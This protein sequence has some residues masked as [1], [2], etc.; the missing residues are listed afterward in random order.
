ME[1]ILKRKSFLSKLHSSKEYAFGFMVCSWNP[2]EE[3]LNTAFLNQCGHVC[4][5]FSPFIEERYIVECTLKSMILLSL[6][7]GWHNCKKYFAMNHF[8]NEFNFLGTISLGENGFMRLLTSVSNC[9]Y[10]WFIVKNE[11]KN[12]VNT[13]FMETCIDRPMEENNGSFFMDNTT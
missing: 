3:N 12:I 8:T 13:F 10:E 6:P 2:I 4:H 7:T 1:Q 11:Y 9:D 5:L